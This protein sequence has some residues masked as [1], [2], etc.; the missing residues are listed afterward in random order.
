MFQST[1]ELSWQLLTS[2]VPALSQP[3]V[4]V[5]LLPLLISIDLELVTVLDYSW[6]LH[7]AKAAV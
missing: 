6:Q 2:G 4:I 5:S 7:K 3:L 1:Q